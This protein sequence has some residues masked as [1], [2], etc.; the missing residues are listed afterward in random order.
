MPNLDITTRSDAP[1]TTAPDLYKLITSG[2]LNAPVINKDPQES[3]LTAFCGH[4]SASLK[5]NLLQAPVEAAV[6]LIDHIADH[7]AGKELLPQVNWYAAPARATV[8][9]AAW[10]GDMAGGM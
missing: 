2:D 1:Q 6:Q 10:M 4:A 8:G 9:S 7:A 5:Y 3:G